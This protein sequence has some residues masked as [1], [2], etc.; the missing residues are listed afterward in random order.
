MFTYMA[1]YYYVVF[2]SCIF[3]PLSV[4]ITETYITSITS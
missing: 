3:D 4:L 1:Y 2:T